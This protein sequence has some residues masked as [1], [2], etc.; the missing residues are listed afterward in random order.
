MTLGARACVPIPP[1]TVTLS[2]AGSIRT[3]VYERAHS[4]PVSSAT[5][6]VSQYRGSQ[7]ERYEGLPNPWPFGPH[8]AVSRELQ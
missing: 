4:S 7:A 8:R 6:G 1:I 3:L 5:T 2:T